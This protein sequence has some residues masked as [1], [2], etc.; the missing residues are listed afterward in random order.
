MPVKNEHDKYYERVI[1][2][3]HSLLDYKLHK[4]RKS[5]CIDN[6]IAM[7]YTKFT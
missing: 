4:S 1:E 2:D 6:F 5:N 7:S 3:A